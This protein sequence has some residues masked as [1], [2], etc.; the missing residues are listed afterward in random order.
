[1]HNFLSNF[2]NSWSRMLLKS[3]LISSWDGQMTL[4]S[5]SQR[6]QKEAGVRGKGRS[7]RWWRHGEKGRGEE[8]REGR[9]VN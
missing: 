4:T 7:A 9:G 2:R 5:P 8:W 6:M 3:I 1:M